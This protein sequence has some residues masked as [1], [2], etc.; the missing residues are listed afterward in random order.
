MIYT[1]GLHMIG[2]TTLEL[3]RFAEHIGMKKSWYQF[4]PTHPHYDLMA[5]HRVERAINKGAILIKDRHEFVAKYRKNDYTVRALGLYQPFASLILRG[6]KFE[7][8]MQPTNVRGTILI[9]S[10]LKSPDTM[11]TY[12]T[13]GKKHYQRSNLALMSED[14]RDLHGYA[15]ALAE[16]VDCRPMTAADEDAAFVP[17]IEGRW[18]W[19]LEHVN[20][21][22]PF[23]WEIYNEKKGRIEN[24]GLQGWRILKLP[25][26]KRIKVRA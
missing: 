20:R 22:V 24:A 21:I 9:Y 3:H 6:K 15:I 18:V 5:K 2:D 19:H 1:D 7:T 14:T 17:S 11:E 25:E 4:H 16:L 13:M 23:K 10:T 26:L 12:H 8:R